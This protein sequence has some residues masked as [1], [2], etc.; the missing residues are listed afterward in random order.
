MQISLMKFDFWDSLVYKSATHCV[1]NRMSEFLNTFS[2]K[3]KW[4]YLESNFTGVAFP[5]GPININ[6]R[7]TNADFGPSVKF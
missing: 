6:W 1:Q 7:W 3:K 4:S 5:A 2:W